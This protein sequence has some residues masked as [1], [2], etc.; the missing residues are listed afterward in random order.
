[1]CGEGIWGLFLQVS[2]ELFIREKFRLLH[3]LLQQNIFNHSLIFSHCFLLQFNRKPI[4]PHIWG[5]GSLI[6]TA[7]LA[8]DMEKWEGKPYLFIQ[9]QP[10]CVAFTVYVL[11]TKKPDLSQTYCLHN[12]NKRLNMW[13]PNTALNRQNSINT[14]TIIQLSIVG[15]VYSESPVHISQ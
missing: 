15:K 4:K 3:R 8:R 6:R 2:I 9:L 12:L 13:E 14:Q 7:V 11:Q 5:V 1:M 10:R